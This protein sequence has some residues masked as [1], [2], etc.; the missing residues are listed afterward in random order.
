MYRLTFVALVLCMVLISSQGIRFRQS[1][2]TPEAAEPAAGAEQASNTDTTPDS[3]PGSHVPYPEF[4][5]LI[6][7]EETQYETYQ[8]TLSAGVNNTEGYTDIKDP[9][10]QAGAIDAAFINQMALSMLPKDIQIF[11]THQFFKIFQNSNF[12]NQC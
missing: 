10:F 1:A 5:G 8:R 9:S 12:S 7:D 6:P 3:A 11:K 2:G 4:S